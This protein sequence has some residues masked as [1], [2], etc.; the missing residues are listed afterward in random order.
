[1]LSALPPLPALQTE[2]LCSLSPS[3]SSSSPSASPLSCIWKL[4]RNLL[5]LSPSRCLAQGRGEPRTQ[6][7][8]APFPAH[9]WEAPIQ[10]AGFGLQR[11]A[12][13]CRHP[14]QLNEKHYTIHPSS[15]PPS[16]LL[17]FSIEHFRKEAV[18]QFILCLLFS[19]PSPFGENPIFCLPEKEKL[20][21]QGLEIYHRG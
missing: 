11:A 4:L 18:Q 20:T 3:S 19:A 7:Q 15:A 1:M 13:E 2:H 5:A 17:N 10:L 16:S 9:T 8:T 12:L 14:H 6:S 21:A